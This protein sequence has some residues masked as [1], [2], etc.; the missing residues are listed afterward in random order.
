M[1]SAQKRSIKERIKELEQQHCNC[2]VEIDRLQKQYKKHG[3][4]KYQEGISRA[5]RRGIIIKRKI[6]NLE[7]LHGPDK[8]QE[9]TEIPPR[10]V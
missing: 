1:E 10:A 4:L 8:V 6:E 5:V 3:K 7:K 2:Q 9:K